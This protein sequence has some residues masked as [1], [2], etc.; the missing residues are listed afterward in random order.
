MDAAAD[1][2][3]EE[4]RVPAA[5]FPRAGLHAPPDV[6]AADRLHGGHAG[7]SAAAALDHA[8]NRFEHVEVVAVDV[9]V[10]DRQHFG[11]FSAEG[12]VDFG[13]PSRHGK[14]RAG[15]E[16]KAQLPG[17]LDHLA[18]PV[19]LPREVLV[20][21]DGNA[22]AALLEDVDDLGEELVPRIERLPLFIARIIAVFADQQDAVDG[23]FS[24]SQT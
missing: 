22:V 10:A 17:R 3:V 11:G 16:G 24:G 18:G 12:K 7:L 21:E 13:Q 4:R 9:A 14:R 23:E 19:P 2:R 6:V 8:L 20:V 15:H 5:R 1:A